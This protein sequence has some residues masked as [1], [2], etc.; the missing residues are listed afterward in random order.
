MCQ[1]AEGESNYLEAVDKSTR[2]RGY[3]AFNA[4]EPITASLAESDHQLQ[5]YSDR[6]QWEIGWLTAESGRDLW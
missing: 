4:G 5:R 1:H 2:Q 3:D 6:H